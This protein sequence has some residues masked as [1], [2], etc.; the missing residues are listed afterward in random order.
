MSNR[1]EPPGG[2]KVGRAPCCRGI[3]CP[4]CGGL[5]RRLAGDCN[6]PDT[7]AR[8]TLD[9]ELAELLSPPMYTWASYWQ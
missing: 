4:S 2:G 8:L 7:P 5:T 6:Q 9:R 1:A 3:S